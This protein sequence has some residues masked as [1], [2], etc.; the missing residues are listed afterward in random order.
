M[1][2]TFDVA[3]A[4]ELA[5][6]ER[7]GFVESRHAGSAV[8]L[9]PEGEVLAS[10]G[11]IEAPVLPRSSMKPLQSLACA[12]AGLEITGEALALS[13]ASHS[14]TDRHVAVVRS[15]LQSV[16]LTEDDLE[17]PVAYPSDTDTYA[18][19]LRD[20]LPQARVRMNCSGKHAA[21]L[22]TCVA[23]EWPTAGYLDPQHP[24]QVHTRELIERLTGEKMTV[25]AIDGCGAPVYGMSLHGLA[26][27][28]HRI[29]TA[30]ERSPF[31]MYR[32]AGALVRAVRENPWGISGPG[33][34]DTIAIETLGVFSKV[35]AEGVQVMVA[36]NGT[37]VALKMI[38][39]NP[40]ANSIVA[41]TLLARA[42]AFT[43]AQIAELEAA[44][45]LDVLGA[46]QPVGRIRVTAAAA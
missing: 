40:R 36:P 35:G 33:R 43:D 39:G 14:G 17:C 4:V 37:T 2:E 6:V 28:L 10:Y 34:D 1:S 3:E 16:G 21:M 32:A 15:M 23:N 44:L 24:L 18:H 25:T 22:M 12:T 31:A 5:V 20:A 7:S 30:S 13:T 29:G 45:N 26:R 11:N 9:S 46:G 38:D 8:V 27:A 41:A 19:M 42:G